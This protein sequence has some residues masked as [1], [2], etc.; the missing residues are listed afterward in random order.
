MG[1]KTKQIL[2]GVAGLALVF[3][4]PAVAGLIGVSGTTLGIATFALELVGYSLAGYAA[5]A[6]AEDAIDSEAYAGLKLQTTKSN[7]APVPIVYGRNKMG[8]N[9]IYQTTN[10]AI[11][12]NGDAGSNRDY[13]AIIVIADH[14]I[15]SL[16]NVWANDQ[17]LGYASGVHSNAYVQ[18]RSGY[19]ASATNV[20]SVQFPTS[21]SATQAGSGLG[22]SSS[23]IPA[24]VHYLAVHQVYD[25]TESANTQMAS[26]T[27]EIKGKKIRSI[28][29]GSISSAESY[30]VNPAE[31][32]LDLLGDALS[33]ADSEID[34]DSFYAAKT[35]CDSHGF[36]VNL[37]LLRKTNVS[38]SLGEVMGT[39][40]G[41]LTHSQNKWKMI[42]DDSGKT[43]VGTL[44][45]DDFIN[46][47]LAISM[48]SNRDIANFIYLRYINP[49]DEWMSAQVI[50]GDTE[51]VALDGQTLTKTL[52]IK[53][54]TDQ[55]HAQK[56]AQITLN[57][58]RYS[59]DGQ[60]NRIKQT[61]ISISFATSIKNAHLEVGDVI[62]IDHSL[63]NRIRTFT[64]L[65]TSTDQ[66]GLIEISAREYCATHYKDD[67]GNQII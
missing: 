30:S 56:L 47:S 35:A 42:V 37:A 36:T 13:W 49:N 38:A 34:I 23:V 55:Q 40:R 2:A 8:G 20:Q 1:D 62:G 59:E 58:G 26:V 4:A 28:N 67:N 24:G 61:P 51:L 53:G 6:Y 66:S 39:C 41:F 3:F 65:S 57:S 17:V 10:S 5:M 52:D 64:I 21:S 50:A 31:I 22:L 43:S 44:T 45:D 19:T 12:G 7:T 32:V 33:V 60:G 48:P 54:V 46:Q 14:D 27:V 15:E 16:V 11:H 9:I 29:S 18:V 25:G 63:F